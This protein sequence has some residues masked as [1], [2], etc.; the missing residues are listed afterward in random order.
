VPPDPLLEMKLDHIL[1][2]AGPVGYASETVRGVKLL[3]DAV[4]GLIKVFRKPTH[5]PTQTPDE[6]SSED[7]LDQLKH[8]VIGNRD[9][10]VRVQLTPD[11]QNTIAEAGNEESWPFGGSSSLRRVGLR[12][13]AD[14]HVKVFLAEF[15][16]GDLSEDDA[17]EFLPLLEAEWNVDHAIKVAG[18]RYKPA[19]GDWQFWLQL[20][21]FFWRSYADPL[22]CIVCGRRVSDD[23]WNNPS[24][25]ISKRTD[26]GGRTGRSVTV[27]LD[28]METGEAMATA[29]GITWERRS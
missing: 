7:S 11:A 29:E 10:T 21:D 2:S 25:W 1:A 19:D 28:C 27:H 3:G 22:A 13:S 8:L 4:A 15:H 23:F 24:V 17:Q 5:T 14:S 16:L 12:L 9:R 6:Q 20:P 26:T 18:W